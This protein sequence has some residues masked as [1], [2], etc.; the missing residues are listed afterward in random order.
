[1]ARQSTLAARW[2]VLGEWRAH[3]GRVVTAAI[4]IA[5]GV[6]LGLAVHLVN[7]SALS[8]FSKAVSA[9]NGEAQLQI[10]AT[11]P[12]GFAENLYPVAARAEGVAMASPVVELDAVTD[13]PDEGLTVLGLDVL[14]AAR[15]T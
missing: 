9:V 1:M 13:R 10:R 8:E 14:R 11:T 3:P 6:A 12:F 5:I 7:A 4:A 15:V 2:M